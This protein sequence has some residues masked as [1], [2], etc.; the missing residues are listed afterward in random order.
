MNRRNFLSATAAFAA[1]SSLA[2]AIQASSNEKFESLNRPW[3]V[4]DTESFAF[5]SQHV[6]DTLA[7]GVKRPPEL[8]MQMRN[9]EGQPL[10]LVYVLDASV[11]LGLALATAQL[12]LID[13]DKPGFPPLL[14]VGID[15]LE[16]KPNARTRDFTHTDLVVPNPGET[17]PENTVGGAD[18][19][20][21]FLEDE[22]DSMIRSRYNVTDKPAGILGISYG[23]TFTF[24]AFRR[25]SKLFDKYF[26][27]S[28]G[29]FTT[30]VDYIGEVAKLLEGQLVHDTKMYLSFGELEMVS[31][32]DMGR[33]FN[34]LVRTLTKAKNPQLEF[35]FKIYP[36]HSHTSIVVPSHNDAVLY[37]Y[38]PKLPPA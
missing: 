29:L 27:G 32:E 18:N 22:L 12:Q 19:Y 4:R 30:G 1:T 28:P 35:D 7:I 6:G 14:L 38:D 34:R 23:G 24:H 37:L 36:D 31:S 16:D 5:H 9:I 8:F 15:Y 17:T 26:L 11:A 3:P 33:N 13:R 2:G 20:L 10:D 21:R 25:Q